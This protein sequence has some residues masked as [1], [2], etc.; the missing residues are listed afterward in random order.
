[1]V[2]SSDFSLVAASKPARAGEILTLFAKGLGPTNPAVPYGRPFPG[3][4]PVITSPVVVNDTSVPALYAGGYPGATDVY[5]V[6]FQMQTGTPPG[7]TTLSPVSG[8][9]GDQVTILV[10]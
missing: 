3:S 6:N 8:F 4:P 10:Q 9:I 5:R 2:N 7:V 1:M